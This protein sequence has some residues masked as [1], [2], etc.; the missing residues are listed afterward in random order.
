MANPGQH[1]ISASEAG[2]RLGALLNRVEAG[3]AVVITRRG[4]PV[5]RLIPAIA[6]HDHV[7]AK[8]AADALL[9]VTHGW[10]LDRVTVN[11]FR[12]KGRRGTQCVQHSQYSYISYN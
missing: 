6:V 9:A 10:R 3:E 7:D 2:N 8:R 1:Q 5:A 11:D 4:R 12:A